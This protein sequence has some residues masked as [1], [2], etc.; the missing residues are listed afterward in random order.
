M[1][2]TKGWHGCRMCLAGTEPRVDTCTGDA[3]MLLPAQ[4]AALGW[5]TVHGQLGIGKRRH[6]RRERGTAAMHRGFR[7]GSCEDAGRSP[8]NT[9]ERGR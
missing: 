3:V 5:Q 2:H 9:W 4:A 8:R 7:G 1:R 6:A